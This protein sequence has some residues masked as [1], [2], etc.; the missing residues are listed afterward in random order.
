MRR[1]DDPALDAVA[2][3]GVEQLIEGNVRSLRLG[4]ELHDVADVRIGVLA[5][6]APRSSPSRMRCSLTTRQRS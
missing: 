6:G 1:R 2:G 5:E 4:P 3:A